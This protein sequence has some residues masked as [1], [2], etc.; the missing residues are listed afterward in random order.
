M[1]VQSQ[2][3]VLLQSKHEYNAQQVQFPLNAEQGSDIIMDNKTA[4]EMKLHLSI[5]DNSSISR[6]NWTIVYYTNKR[7]VA[8]HEFVLLG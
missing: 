4:I 7:D 1:A 2:S 5:S 3:D 6:A 8:C